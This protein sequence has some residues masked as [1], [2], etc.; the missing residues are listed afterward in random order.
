MFRQPKS[1]RLLDCRSGAPLDPAYIL[2]FFLLLD[3]YRVL[4]IYLA[5]VL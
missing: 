5:Q 3:G 2:R 4:P 1:P